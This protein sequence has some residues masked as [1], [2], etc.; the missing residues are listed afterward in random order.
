[1]GRETTWHFSTTNWA[2]IDGATRST[3]FLQARI[4]D[5]LVAGVD[6][7]DALAAVEAFFSQHPVP[8]AERTLKQALETA[9]LRSVRRAREEAVLIAWLAAYA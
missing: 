8:L 5:S 7:A 1:M 6:S 2:K 4:I 9:R 3:S